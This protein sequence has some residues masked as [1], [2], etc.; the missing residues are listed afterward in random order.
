MP[1]AHSETPEHVRATLGAV[2]RRLREAAERSLGDV[3]Q[4]AGLS[5]GFLSEI[6]RGRKDVSTDKLLRLCQALDTTIA[7]VFLELA[8]ELGAQ[9]EPVWAVSPEADPR[10]QLKRAARVLDHQALRSVAQ[11]SAYLA[12][13]QE[14]TPPRRRIGF[15]S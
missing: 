4:P 15:L 14:Q 11:F 13:T 8:R 9:V 2:L 10:L 6:E 7:D 5:I 1:F 3:A 12:M